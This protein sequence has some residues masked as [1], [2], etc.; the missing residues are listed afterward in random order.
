MAC[1]HKVAGKC[2]VCGTQDHPTFRCYCRYQPAPE[3]RINCIVSLPIDQVPEGVRVVT[4]TELVE[5]FPTH[6]PAEDVGA[7]TPADPVCMNLHSPD[8]PVEAIPTNA[9]VT[10]LVAGD[11]KSGMPEGS[12]VLPETTA[13]ITPEEP[14]ETPGAPAI[15]E[16]VS[17]ALHH[18]N[19]GDA[20][21]LQLLPGLRD[22][23]PR[24]ALSQ[25]DFGSAEILGTPVWL[26][27]VTAREKE[28]SPEQRVRPIQDPNRTRLLYYSVAFQGHTC[29]TLLDC[30]ASHSFLAK[31][32]LTEKNLRCVPLDTPWRLGIF[33]GHAEQMIREVCR[34]PHVTVGTLDVLWTFLVLSH[35]NHKAILGLDFI[36]AHGLL[37]DPR[38]DLLVTLRED[39]ATTESLPNDGTARRIAGDSAPDENDEPETLLSHTYVYTKELA[40]RSQFDRSGTRV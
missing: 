23:L 17:P 29:P 35:S 4:D 9:E 38:S 26:Q 13:P 3:S 15:A 8:P 34:V 16:D 6:S 22:D 10:K 20:V 30:G 31:N 39:Q 12:R 36:R 25:S 28:V 24:E 33:D 5:Q 2:G 7:H 1:S 32:W 14:C 19:S 40:T 37:Y 18:L 27:A 11:T 21:G